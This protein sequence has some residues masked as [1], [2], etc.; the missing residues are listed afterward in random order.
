[1]NLTHAEA[2]KE[3]LLALA[4]NIP[5]AWVGI[6]I[7]ALLLV[8]EGQRPGWISEVLG[9]TRMSLSRWIHSVNQSGLSALQ[10]RTRSGRPTRLTSGM[11]K[12]A[13]L[14]F[15]KES[16]RVRFKPCSLGWA[17]SGRAF[18]ASVW[19]KA[20]GEAG[21]ALDASVGVPVEASQLC[22][23]SSPLGTGQ[24]VSGD[25]KKNLRPWA[26]KKR[27]SFRTRLVLPCIR[28]WVAV[29]LVLA[30]GCGWPRPASIESV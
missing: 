1:M 23:S 13:C 21:S 20:N 8:L 4:E 28:A 22:L 5:G 14:S 7:A 24:T 2:K 26:P 9:L 18:E 19:T 17:H 16:R 10:P 30:S 6:K 29:G 12:D 11:Q 25:F 3:R 15:R 27:L